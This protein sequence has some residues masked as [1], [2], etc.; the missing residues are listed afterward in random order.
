VSKVN[1]SES[2]FN[3]VLVFFVFIQQCFY[4][5]IRILPASFSFEQP[6]RD[7]FKKNSDAK[8]LCNAAKVRSFFRNTIKMRNFSPSCIMFPICI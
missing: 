5:T 3:Y 7:H 4:F 2:R 1:L 6:V 8:V